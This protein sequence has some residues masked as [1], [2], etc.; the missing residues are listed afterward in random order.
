MST[1]TDTDI[2][3]AGGGPA[4]LAAALYAARL[5][6]RVTVVEPRRQPV[7]KACGE[8][9]MP[10][11]LRA[12][13]ELGLDPVGHVIAGIRYTDGT[14]Q[15]E[16]RFRSGPGRGVRRTTLHR[17]LAAAAE[18][19]GVRWLEGRVAGVRQG[20]DWVQ[21]AGL[22]GR[23]LLA[24][25]GLHSP[26]RRELGLHGHSR[27]PARFGLRRHYAVAPWSDLVEV[28]WAPGAEAYVTPVDERL[29][30]VAVLSGPGA[31]YPEG[32]SRFPAL[33]ERLG[34]APAVTPVR[35]AGPLR[36]DVRA[37][38]AGRVLLI[39]DA[40]GYVDALT[41]EGLT[42]GLRSGRAAV[43]CLLSGRPE[44]YEL[45]W[46]RLSRSYR[47]LTAALLRASSTRGVGPAIVPAAARLPGV[48]D[49][50]VQTLAG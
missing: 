29:V 2:L 36:Q 13:A 38:T 15:V 10:S 3:V 4:G 6:Q 45:A 14:R 40:A 48:F 20:P 28:H 17:E 11:A 5:G 16:S 31:S 19:A 49:R 30:G 24:A 12:L 22:R 32:L 1:P 44:A 47:L 18:A 50:A 34:D 35:G 46:R 8:G 41:G 9:L 39:G 42:L 33:V 37:R 7:D 43:D 21:A 27:R 26:V 25:D 23:W